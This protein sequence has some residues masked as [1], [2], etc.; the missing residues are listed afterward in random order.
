MRSRA[1]HARYRRQFEKKLLEYRDEKDAFEESFWLLT[2]PTDRDAAKAAY[3]LGRTSSKVSYVSFDTLIRE[4]W[5]PR[6]HLLILHLSLV[7]LLPFVQSDFGRSLDG[8]RC[9]IDHVASRLFALF[10]VFERG[11]LGHQTLNFFLKWYRQIERKVKRM[12][13][14]QKYTE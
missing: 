11:I 14:M 4:S 2:S 8:A 5:A 10:T 13:V 6:P 12:Q 3:R 1:S 7:R 9:R